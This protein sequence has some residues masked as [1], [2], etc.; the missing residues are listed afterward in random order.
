[1]RAL[2][3][4]RADSGV[5][6][7]VTTHLMEEAEKC[8]R[9]AILDHGRLPPWEHPM[10]CVQNRRRLH[11]DPS[12]R[13]EQ[14]AD[15]AR[16]IE[17]SLQQAPQRFDAQ[18]RLRPRMEPSSSIQLTSQFAGD[19]RSITLGKPTL[20]DVFIR[21]TGHQFWDEGKPETRRK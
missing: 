1:M 10:S 11:L 17:S 2:Q 4:L 18:L 13:P 16:R 20:E 7:L 3:S 9:L 21:S 8:D 6:V 19:I 15:L 12:S 14:A 5:T